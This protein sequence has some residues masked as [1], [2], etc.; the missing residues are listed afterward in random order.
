ME[1]SCEALLEVENH[2]RLGHMAISSPEVSPSDLMLCAEFPEGHG[3]EA[4]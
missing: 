3:V 4:V 1:L 2:G